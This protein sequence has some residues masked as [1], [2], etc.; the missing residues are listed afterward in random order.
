M[1][2]NVRLA[3]RIVARRRT[4]FPV[5]NSRQRTRGC[6]QM[7]MITMSIDHMDH[8][9]LVRNGSG[10]LSTRRDGS[11]SSFRAS[12]RPRGCRLSRRDD[13]IDQV[14]NRGVSCDRWHSYGHICKRSYGSFRSHFGLPAN[15]NISIQGEPRWSS[16]RTQPAQQNGVETAC[17]VLSGDVLLASKF[18]MKGASDIGRKDSQRASR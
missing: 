12:S 17:S 16:Q 18:S 14:K 9:S 8:M 7:I 6:E 4:I 5:A 3:P 10:P 13:A 11:L 2:A 15:T 1:V